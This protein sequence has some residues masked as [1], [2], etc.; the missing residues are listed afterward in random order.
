MMKKKSIKMA[1]GMAI[2]MATGVSL[3]AIGAM[4]IPGVANSKFVK[5]TKKTLKRNAGKA[6]STVESLVDSLPKMLG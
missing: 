6:I 2:G 3:G 1:T 4:Q 5:Q